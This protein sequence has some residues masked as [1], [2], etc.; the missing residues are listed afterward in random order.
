[1]FKNNRVNSNSYMILGPTEGLA[2]LLY[3]SQNTS[4]QRAG[5]D[6]WSADRHVQEES[7]WFNGNL[8]IIKVIKRK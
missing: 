7:I 3:R 4:G 1:M 5:R 6:H 8:S 2:Q